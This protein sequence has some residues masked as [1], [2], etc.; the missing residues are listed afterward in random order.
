[1]LLACAVAQLIKKRTIVINGHPNNTW[2]YISRC[3]MSVCRFP[4]AHWLLRDTQVW[5]M[6]FPMGKYARWRREWIGCFSCHLSTSTLAPFILSRREQQVPLACKFPHSWKHQTQFLAFFFFRTREGNVL[7][8]VSGAN[9]NMVF[10]TVS[11]KFPNMDSQL[12]RYPPWLFEP[13]TFFWH[14]PL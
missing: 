9:E 10:Y 6:C 13:L 8:I 2:N 7:K 1:M 3:F 11:W 14:H 12:Y 4:P 5:E